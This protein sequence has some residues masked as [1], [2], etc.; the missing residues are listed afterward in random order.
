MREEKIT[1]KQA[2]QALGVDPLTLREMLKQDGCPIG[3]A[4]KPAGHSRWTYVIYPKAF[5][6]LVGEKGEQDD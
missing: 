2:S 4:F 1:I 3:T 5:K 6:W